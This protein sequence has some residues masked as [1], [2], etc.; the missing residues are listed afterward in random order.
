MYQEVNVMIYDFIEVELST[1]IYYILIPVLIVLKYTNK[2]WFH[3]IY[4]FFSVN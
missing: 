4:L 3:F 2:L 1:L